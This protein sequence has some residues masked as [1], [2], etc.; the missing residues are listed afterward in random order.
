V[1]NHKSFIAKQRVERGLEHITKKSK[2][3]IEKK[4]F[5]VQTHCKSEKCG[6]AQIIDADRQKQIFDA[7]YQEMGWTQKTLYIRSC[8]KRKPVES[9]KSLLH[10]LIP[11]KRRDF[12]HI[13]NLTN[14]KGVANEVCREFFMNCIQVTSG[15]IFGA[16]N[17]NEKNPAAVENRGKSSAVNKTSDFHHQ[18]VCNFI[19]RIPKYESHYG[20]NKSQKKYLHHTLNMKTL[21]KEYKGNCDPKK[22]ECVSE[23]IFREIFT[24]EYNLSFKRRHTDTCKTCDEINNGLRSSLISEQHKNELKGKHKAHLELVENVRSVFVADVD[25]ASNSD[26][27]TV[28]LTFDLQKTLETPSLSTSVAYYKRQLW[29]YNL[30]IYDEGKK[31]AFMYVWSENVASRGGQEIGSC[32]IKHFKTHIPADTTKIILYSDS[33]GGQNKNIKLTMLLKKYLHDLTPENAL[34]S[35]EQKYFTSGHSYNSCDR[36]FGVIEKH[37]K[38]KDQI[39]TPNDW[40]NL[41]AE[42]KKSSP[43]FI[44]YMMQKFDFVSCVNLLSIIVNRKK[45]PDGTKINWFKIRSFQ[46]KKDEPFRLFVVCIDGTSHQLNIQKKQFDDESLTMCNLPALFP[47]GNAISKKKYDDLIE[48]LKY[49]PADHHEF[50][51]KLNQQNDKDDYGLA[52]DFS[53]DE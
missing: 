29:T 23:N 51:T 8:V 41:I 24:T 9:K 7:F 40:L 17:K 2:K 37:R 26:N 45:T 35:I 31:Q 49:V 13:Y 14:E 19:D 52:S 11:L 42:A 15:R 34:Q 25:N 6:C 44:V 12:N 10:P 30:C 39:Y 32:L 16:L 38:T 20:R 4:V 46:Y 27:K 50:F 43:Q 36:C 48:L 53:D 22:G 28:V 3:L 5:K 21:Y 18:A 47:E 1:Q 33:C